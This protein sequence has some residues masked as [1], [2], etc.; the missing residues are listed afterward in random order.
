[1]TDTKCAEPSNHKSE[2]DS[3]V[4]CVVGFRQEKHFWL[5]L[6]NERG[7]SINLDCSQ[8]NLIL[9]CKIRYVR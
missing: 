7:L 3:G 5:Q 1:M 2:F 4:L 9:Y 8:T 6:E